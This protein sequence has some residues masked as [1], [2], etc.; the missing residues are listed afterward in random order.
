MSAGLR[1]YRKAAANLAPP[2]ERAIAAHDRALDCLRQAL[3]T[4][5]RGEFALHK[6]LL[7]RAIAL[8]GALPAEI[9]PERGGELGQAL[10][11]LY[12][13][14]GARLVEANARGGEVTH[15]GDDSPGGVGAQD[16]AARPGLAVCGQRS[17]LCATGP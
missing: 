12:D 1:A 9:D 6:A 5:E 11:D 17:D 13:Y 8:V 2:H 7:C 10:L 4:Q 16:K 3:A 14:M 15:R